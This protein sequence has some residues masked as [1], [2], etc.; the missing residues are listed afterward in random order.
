MSVGR[1]PSQ[2]KASE[3]E[4]SI[5]QDT[6]CQRIELV[7]WTAPAIDATVH[8]IREKGTQL[9]LVALGLHTSNLLSFLLV[10][11]KAAVC[12]LI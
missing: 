6:R 1:Q 3:R 9:S 8:I 5:E 12:C 10:G 11:T 4:P 7:Q 2:S